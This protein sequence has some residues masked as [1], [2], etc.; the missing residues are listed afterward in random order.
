MLL[1]VARYVSEPTPEKNQIKPPRNM[2]LITSDSFLLEI[3]PPMP[4]RSSEDFGAFFGNKSDPYVVVRFGAEEI[5]ACTGRHRQ[6]TY[7]DMLKSC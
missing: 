3:I 5:L 7:V 6:L 2:R 1:L 4:T